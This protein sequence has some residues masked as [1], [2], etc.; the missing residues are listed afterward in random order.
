MNIFSKNKIL[1]FLFLVLSLKMGAQSVGGT[2]TAIPL[3]GFC[4]PSGG[5]FLTLSGSS[6]GG[7]PGPPPP[8]VSV[9]WESST[10][11]I[12]WANTGV[13]TYQQGYSALTQTTWYRAI[14]TDGAW[15]PDT[16]SNIARITVYQPSVGGTVINGGV[17]CIGAGFLNLT[18]YVG[19]ILN[20][21]SSTD[22]GI[23]WTTLGNTTNVLTYNITQSTIY[24]ALVQNSPYCLVD[25][26]STGFVT[27]SITKAGT[28]AIYPYSGDSI[29]GSVTY[30]GASDS[31][32]IKLTGNV[33][34]ILHW[35][36][37]SDG[38][39]SLNTVINDTTN[40]LNYSNITQNTAF[41]AVVQLGTCAT[42]T[43]SKVSFTIEN[44][45]AG[46]IINADTTVEYQENADT[47]KLLGSSGNKIEWQYSTDNGAVWNSAGN[48]TTALP[49]EN[50]VDTTKYRVLVQQ[51]SCKKDTSNVVTINVLPKTIGKITNLFT[52]NG[53]GINDTWFIKG[54]NHYEDNEV[55]VY[56]IYGNLVFNK[57]GY[58]N[59]WKGTYN[60]A[61]LPDGTYYYVVKLGGDSDKIIKGSLD[62]L[63]GK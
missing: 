3:F 32:K 49:Y 38:G 20:W 16:S 6:Y 52:P 47:L 59:D 63:R 55:F 23:S 61:E 33:G 62:I 15:P 24:K 56:N 27:L 37:S 58:K 10:D 18:G 19:S 1:A 7:P 39:A 53:D 60:G 11:S 13:T 41:A 28:T 30:C 54:L 51:N 43:S 44:S 2:I 12:T 17:F 48:I 46:K 14:V 57:K 8:G 25:S 35:L 5:G 4:S 31:G 22:G 34:R 21:L 45:T 42:E 26:S 40:S 9:R 36:T 29:T 50:L